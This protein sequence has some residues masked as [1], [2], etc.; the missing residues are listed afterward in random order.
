MELLRKTWR[1]LNNEPHQLIGVRVLQIALGAKLLLDVFMLLPFA[2]FF[3]GP[4]GIGWGST[5]FVLGPTL[6]NLFD[7]VFSTNACIFG[8]LALMAIGALGLVV[9]YNTRFAALLALIP[10]FLIQKR[11]PEIGDGGDNLTQL[12][13]IYMLLLLPNRAKFSSGQFR[14]W[15]HNIGVLAITFQLVIVYFIAGFGKAYGDWWQQ[16]VALYYIT[17]V[18]WFTLPGANELFTNPWLVTIAT[19]GSMLYELLFPTAIISRLKL[20]WI[21]FGILFHIGIA[22]IMGMVSFATVMIGLDLF[23]ISDQEYVQIWQQG[24]LFLTNLARL[25]VQVYR[26][27]KKP[28]KGLLEESERVQTDHE[29]SLKIDEEEGDRVV[30]ERFA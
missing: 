21:L 5:K 26:I 12:V 27:F 6:G 4:N 16:G 3:W 28:E 20:P 18:Q 11:L 25:P 13:L 7:R 15:L 1:W 24:Q 2:T 19:Y 29:E 8:T 22:V 14:V 17:Q 10:L 9:G 30:H 23:L